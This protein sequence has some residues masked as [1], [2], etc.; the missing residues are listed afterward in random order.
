M[1]KHLF[2]T[3]H[4]QDKV[5]GWP[6][7]RME[8]GGSL[9]AVE[10]SLRHE[11]AYDSAQAMAYQ[12]YHPEMDNGRYLMALRC[13]RC[14]DRVV[15]AGAYGSEEVELPDRFE[16]EEMLYPKFFFPALPIIEIPSTC[17]QGVRIALTQAFS[18]YWSS[19]G[20]T[21][22]SMRI[23][24]ERLMDEQNIAAGNLHRRIEIFDR[25]HPETGEFLEAAKWVGN[26]GSHEGEVTHERVLDVLELVEHALEVLYPK[27]TTRL[28]DTARAIIAAKGK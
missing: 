20:N 18:A 14:D 3:Y 6:C 15:V 21:A 7:T 23:A 19:P 10:G 12:S 22:N 17:P 28:R 11:G 4:S 9:D 24:L 25:S 27:D 16:H 26:V 8:C 1:K 2:R 13:T 5:P